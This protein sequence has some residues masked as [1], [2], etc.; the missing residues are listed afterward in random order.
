M[1]GVH[2]LYARVFQL[3]VY[4]VPASATNPEP[5]PEAAPL[6]VV[7]VLPRVVSVDSVK[8]HIVDVR[9]CRLY[10]DT[11]LKVR[12]PQSHRRHQRVCAHRAT[13]RLLHTVHAVTRKLPR[14][15]SRILVM[16]GDGIYMGSGRLRAWVDSLGLSTTDW[17]SPSTT[18]RHACTAWEFDNGGMVRHRSRCP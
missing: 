2:Y 9:F 3:E 13:P 16:Q 6:E 12:R 11:K 7:Y 10:D 4:D 15:R 5:Q 14:T 8:G 17:C 18:C 1:G